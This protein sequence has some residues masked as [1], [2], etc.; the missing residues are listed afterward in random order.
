MKV[1]YFVAFFIQELEIMPYVIRYIWILFVFFL[2]QIGFLRKIIL[3]IR[4]GA[5]IHQTHSANGLQ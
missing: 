3:R 4:G 5:K 2:E 1:G